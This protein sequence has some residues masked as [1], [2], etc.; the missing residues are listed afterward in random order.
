MGSMISPVLPG[1][2]RQALVRGLRCRCPRCGE[3]RLFRA[4]L[5]PVERC[6]VCT[7]DLTPQ[8]ADDLPAYIAI[9]ITGH[10][11]APFLIALPVDF[12]L[13]PLA[14]A[15]ILIPLATVAMLG[16]LQPVKG[17]VIAAQWWFGMHGFER[18]RPPH[19][20]ETA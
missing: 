4:W 18:E 1:T 6:P 15:A 7:L 9:L 20:I 13:G 8:R 3:G 2:F 10:V 12:G 19:E 16:M 17:G 5:K 14:V 11:M